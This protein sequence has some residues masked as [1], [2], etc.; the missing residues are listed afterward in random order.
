MKKLIPILSVFVLTLAIWPGQASAKSR[1]CALGKKF[2]RKLPKET[3]MKIMGMMLDKLRQGLLV[4]A[5]MKMA[6]AKLKLAITADQPDMDKIKELIA[7]K[8]KEKKKLA[9][10]KATFMVNVQ[11]LLKGKNLLKLRLKILKGKK[12]MRGKKSGYR[13]KKLG[14][15]KGKRH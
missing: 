2:M 1:G 9:L 12:G 13:H 14:G 11:K 5:A 4:K 3:R 8:Y 6:K 7:A 15:C 10:M